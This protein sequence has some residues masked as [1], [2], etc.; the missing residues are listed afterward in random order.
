M[1]LVKVRCVRVPRPDGSKRLTL[2]DVV[3]LKRLL[4]EDKAVQKGQ[5]LWEV[6]GDGEASPAKAPATKPAQA[7]TSKPTTETKPLAQGNHKP[8]PHANKKQQGS[9]TK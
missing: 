5:A 8:H 9:K 7:Q 3:E 1:S 2:M 4:K 6:L